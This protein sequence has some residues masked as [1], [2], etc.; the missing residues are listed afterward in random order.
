MIPGGVASRGALSERIDLLSRVGAWT[1]DSRMDAAL[2]IEALNRALGLRRLEPEMLIIYT[3]QG[4]QYG[5]IDGRDRLSMHEIVCRMS[6]G[7]LLRQ[8]R[9]GELC[10]HPPPSS[11][12]LLRSSSWSRISMSISKP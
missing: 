9:A 1:L 2:G 12:R 3:D 6:Q 10:L 8:C 4:S 11:R 5:D 7:L